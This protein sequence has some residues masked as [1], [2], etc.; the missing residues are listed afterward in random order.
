MP[1]SKT[2]SA[3]KLKVFLATRSL[4]ILITAKVTISLVLTK[5][6]EVGIPHI[7]TPFSRWGTKAGKS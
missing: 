6:C 4:K 3:Q 1:I 5:T 7:A 2:F